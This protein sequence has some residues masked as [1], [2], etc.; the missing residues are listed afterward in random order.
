MGP[1]TS[2]SSDL[3]RSYAGTKFIKV[4]VFGQRPCKGNKSCRNSVPLSIC[5]Y[6]YPLGP[7][8]GPET[9]L[10][11]P[12]APLIGPQAPMTGPQAPLTG[13]H[14]LLTTLR[15]LLQAP[16]AFRSL[17]KAL[18]PAPFVILYYWI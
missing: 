14:A 2:I 18:R 5:L 4:M 8:I 7:Q 6:V 15:V 9:V 11:G 12:K 10:A 16:R 3:F 1:T 17:W 13:P